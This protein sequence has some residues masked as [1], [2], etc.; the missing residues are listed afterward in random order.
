MQDL[1][2]QIRDCDVQILHS[3][4]QIW[5]LDVRDKM[6]GSHFQKHADLHMSRKLSPKMRL[7]L[8]CVAD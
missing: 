5:D 7:N 8:P 4:I 6:A 2:V 1:D 3:D